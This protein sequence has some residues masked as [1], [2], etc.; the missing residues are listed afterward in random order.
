MPFCAKLSRVRASSLPLNA[1]MLIV[2]LVKASLTS[3]IPAAAPAYEVESPEVEYKLV[4]KP[5]AKECVGN[6]R[7]TPSDSNLR[8][9]FF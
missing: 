9:S 1:I 2:G 8:F 6:S 3:L 5:A 4:A 7:A